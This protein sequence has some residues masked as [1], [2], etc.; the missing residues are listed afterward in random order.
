MVGTGARLAM[1]DCILSPLSGLGFYCLLSTG[2]RPW[3]PLLAR[4]RRFEAGTGG[5]ASL[6]GDGWA[7]LSLFLD[8]G[9]FRSYGEA[10]DGF[11][12]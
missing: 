8:G 5:M 11:L 7:W 2:L 10:V 4:L 12:G 6:S 1:I 9:G 3:Q